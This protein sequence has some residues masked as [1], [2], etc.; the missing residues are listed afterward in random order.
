MFIDTTGRLPP[1]RSRSGRMGGPLARLLLLAIS[2]GLTAGHALAADFPTKPIRIILGY[3]E[4][5]TADNL[6]RLVAA[7]LTTALG[8]SVIF[9][10]R[11]GASGNIA[12][13]FVAR[14]APDGYTILFGN[15]AEMAINK[16]TMR[17][18]G[19]NPDKDFTPVVLIHNVPLALLTSAKSPYKSV[20]QLM[21]AARAKPGVLSFANSGSGSPA[22]LGGEML[23]MKSGV[24]MI[25]V[26]YKGASP[27]MIDLIGGRVDAY[28]L[29]LP[30]ALPHVAAGTVRMLAIS[31]S[32]RSSISPSTPTISEAAGIDGFDFSLWGGFF[33]PAGT[34]ATTVMIL[35]KA[36]NKI[37]QDPAVRAAMLQQGSEA[38]QNSPEEFGRFVKSQSSKYAD[39][40]KETGYKAE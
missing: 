22:H 32:A 3:S 2:L 23:A 31:T 27:A 19:F 21:D 37:L 17:N 30:G 38:V 24:N 1:G 9:E 13:Q 20:S 26:P 25:Q 12:A 15:T 29:G 16:N 36:V 28:L 34:P 5:G 11:P 7:K 10:N 14:S 33:V 6:G 4:G 39:I 40:V 35:N 8:Q 18:M